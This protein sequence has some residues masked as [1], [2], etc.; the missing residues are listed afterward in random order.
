MNSIKYQLNTDKPAE[1]VYLK[2]KNFDGLSLYKDV[3]FKGGFY[4][5]DNIPPKY[6][7][8]IE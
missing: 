4:T 7:E 8:V 1:Y 5:Y 3:R 6:I 2:I